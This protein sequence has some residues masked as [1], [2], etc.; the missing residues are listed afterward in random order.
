MN[1]VFVLKSKQYMFFDLA[2]IVLYFLSRIYLETKTYL[3]NFTHNV[4]IYLTNLCRWRKKKLSENSFVSANLRRIYGIRNILLMYSI[5]G[6]GWNSKKIR[7]GMKFATWWKYRN[8][9]K[10]MLMK[11]NSRNLIE[12]YSMIYSF[13]KAFAFHPRGWWGSR[14]RILNCWK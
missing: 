7:I 12:K 1:K 2:E 9:K 4:I 5:H 13:G 6:N 14:I 3:M 10:M 11:K 8:K